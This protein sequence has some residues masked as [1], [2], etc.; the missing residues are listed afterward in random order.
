MSYFV[1]LRVNA[2]HTFMP[3]ATPKAGTMGL[4][5]LLR[6]WIHNWSVDLTLVSIP[7][8]FCQEHLDTGAP[9]T[10]III[11]KGEREKIHQRGPKLEVD[12]RYTNCICWP[13]THPAGM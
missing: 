1:P 6:L 12:F 10:K 3:L 2:F 7:D 9:D 11:R 8:T 13:L 5:C 4:W